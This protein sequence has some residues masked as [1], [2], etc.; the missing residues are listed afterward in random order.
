MHDRMQFLHK[1]VGKCI[2]R[3]SGEFVIL[4]TVRSFYSRK[5]QAVYI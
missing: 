2:N 1:S 5:E 3:H 4:S